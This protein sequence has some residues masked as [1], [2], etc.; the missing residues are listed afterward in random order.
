MRKKLALLAVA[1]AAVTVVT[2]ATSA[3]A[4]TRIIKG[5]YVYYDPARNMFGIGDTE[6]DG[7][8]AY[9]EVVVAGV[10]KTFGNHNGNGTWRDVYANETGIRDGISLSWRAKVGGGQTSTWVHEPA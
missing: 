10:S 9:V 1:T 8:T 7:R 3:S 6:A 5:A 2:V 4:D